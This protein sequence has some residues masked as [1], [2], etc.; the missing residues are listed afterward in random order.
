VATACRR[1]VTFLSFCSALQSLP[2]GAGVQA[3][4]APASVSLDV[5]SGSSVLV[6]LTPP[7]S[8]GGAAVQSYKVD[9]DTAPGVREV[10]VVRTSVNT[11]PNEVQTISTHCNDIDEVQT[12]STAATPVLEVQRVVV[13]GSTG[14]YFTLQ[15]D[16]SASGGS[17]QLSGQLAHNAAASTVQT[18]LR[19][20]QNL[21]T[22][23]VT[24]VTSSTTGSPGPLTTTYVSCDVYRYSDSLCVAVGSKRLLHDYFTLQLA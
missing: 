7:L 12:V 15:L 18:V 13:S 3:P 2:L 5:V 1:A 17:L 23:A 19:A 4:G 8:D 10:Q 6:G 21:G 14:G 11:G 24:A 16:T 9:W 22:V 20:M